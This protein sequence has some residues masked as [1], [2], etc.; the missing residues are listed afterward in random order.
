MTHHL[1]Y[2]DVWSCILKFI[3][4]H[5]VTM[6]SLGGCH[7]NWLIFSS[8]GREPQESVEVTFPRLPNESLLV[9]E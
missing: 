7:G 6:L 4:G 5:S 2:Y 3:V 9:L 8:T 1:A